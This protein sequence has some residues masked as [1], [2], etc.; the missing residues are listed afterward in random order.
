[1]HNTKDEITEMNQQAL[2]LMERLIHPARHELIELAGEPDIGIDLVFEHIAMMRESGEQVPSPILTLQAILK[3][4][5]V[6]KNFR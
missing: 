2:E 4:G 1:M 6:T 5:K 3:R